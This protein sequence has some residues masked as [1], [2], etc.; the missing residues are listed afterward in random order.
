M[1]KLRCALLLLIVISLLLSLP[2][3]ALAGTS[4]DT[5]E[6]HSAVVSKNLAEAGDLLIVFHYEIA[7][8]N[9][10]DYPT[11]PVDD[12]FLFQLMTN[13]GSVTYAAMAPYPYID[14][15]YGEGVASFYFTA[16][17]VDILGLEWYNP[18]LV[19]I[20]TKLGWVDP[21]V[22]DDYTLAETDYCPAD[23]QVDNRIWLKGWIMETAQSL[24]TDWG[25]STSLTTVSIESVLSE[26]GEGYFLRVIPGLRY[27]CPDLFT[28]NVSCPE[29]PLAP[30]T[31]I[32]GDTLKDRSEYD[33]TFVG[34]AIEG[35]DELTDGNSTLA[36]NVFAVLLIIGL[37]ALSKHQ[38]N[39]AR[40]GML[41]GLYTLPIGAELRFT[42]LAVVGFVALLYTLFT[43]KII[44]LDKG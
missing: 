32:H 13:T 17:K 24:E 1:L 23:P 34:S 26:Y 25:L 16:D 10:N 42:E 22:K 2:G 37:M 40:P 5:L 39:T 31:P 4:P 33:G 14:N 36:L 35:L 28:L 15:G 6:I 18:Y 9:E 41:I 12:Y 11:D 19:R 7:W 44:F 38:L 21:V 3:V 30:G 43:A 29:D 8:D 20:T 27:L